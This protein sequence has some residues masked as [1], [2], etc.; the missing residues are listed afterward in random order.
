MN[1]R[2]NQEIFQFF[3]SCF[4]CDFSIINLLSPHGILHYSAWW[5]KLELPPSSAPCLHQQPAVV[6]KSRWGF[7]EYLFFQVLTIF[8]VKFCSPPRD[9]PHVS[10]QLHLELLP[11]SYPCHIVSRRWCW[12]D[13]EFLIVSFFWVFYSCTWF[14]ELKC[15]II[16]A[17]NAFLSP[18]WSCCCLA[19]S[20][21]T[22][23]SN[24]Q[25]LLKRM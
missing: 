5:L 10:P 2:L 13:G 12:K 15:Y 25:L 7:N 22:S 19:P 24:Q 3:H 16:H 23:I 9:P 6:T 14:F 1:A 11:T 20:P 4:V 18:D 17:T 21:H 8:S